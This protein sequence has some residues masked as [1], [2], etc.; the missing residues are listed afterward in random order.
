M[1]QTL[2]GYVDGS[3]LDE[4]ADEIETALDT[5]VASATWVCGRPKIVNQIHERD[6]S[7]GP[8]DLADWDLGLNLDVP[9]PGSEPAGWFQDVEQVARLLGQVVARTGRE[10]VIGIGDSDTG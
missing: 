4:V 3:D 1:A 5:L 10:F 6:E 2:Y 7:C 8:D 9:D